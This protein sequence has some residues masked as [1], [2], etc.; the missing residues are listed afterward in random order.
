MYYIGWTRGISVPY[1]SSLG[2]AVSSDINSKFY[3]IN[4]TPII[5]RNKNDTIFTST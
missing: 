5:G 3:K 1:I 4:N 2:L